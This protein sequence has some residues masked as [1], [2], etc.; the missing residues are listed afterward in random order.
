MEGVRGRAEGWAGLGLPVAITTKHHKLG[1][2]CLIA[3]SCPPLFA[4]PWTVARQ[5]PLS[6][7]FSRQEYWSGLPFSSP[8]ALLN[9]RIESESPVLQA[10]SL[11]LSHWVSSTNWVL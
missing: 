11:P 10:D 5:V 8:G 1:C 2:C 7:E 4:T 9:L 6:K 3:Q